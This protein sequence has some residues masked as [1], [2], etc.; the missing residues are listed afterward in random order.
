MILVISVTILKDN[1]IERTNSQNAARYLLCIFIIAQSFFFYSEKGI[2][3]LNVSSIH[4]NAIMQ[5]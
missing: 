1:T 5:Y 3:L 2:L 4:L